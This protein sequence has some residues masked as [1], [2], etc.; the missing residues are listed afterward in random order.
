MSQPFFEIYTQNKITGGT[1][2]FWGLSRCFNDPGPYMFTVEWAETPTGEWQVVPTG[3][4][5]DTYWA[6]DPVQRLYAKEFELYYRIR[7]ETPNGQHTSFAQQAAGTWN[8]REWLIAR[9]ICRKEWLR[10]SKQVGVPCFLLKRK[11]AGPRCETCVDWDNNRD[12]AVSDCPDCYGTGITGGYWAPFDT[13]MDTST[14]PRNKEFAEN[15]GLKEDV[16]TEVR[17][18]GYPHVSTYDILVDKSSDRRWVVR[19][20]ENVAELRGQ[21]L[22]Y[23]AEIRL[24]PFTDPIYKIPMTPPEPPPYVQHEDEFE[25]PVVEPEEIPVAPYCPPVGPQPE[26][27][28][29]APEVQEEAPEEPETVEGVVDPQLG[30]NWAPN[31]DDLWIWYDNNTQTWAIGSMNPLLVRYSSQRDSD[32]LWPYLG[33]LDWF[34]NGTLDPGLAISYISQS[35]LFITGAVDPDV[36]GSYHTAG[37]YN[38]TYMFHRSTE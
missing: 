25:P 30:P 28:E 20:V 10:L 26:A 24:A 15:V 23:T 32:R 16:V 14:F 6:E 4:L 13:F 17:L 36:N 9:D 27:Q 2:I 35:N 29:E 19:K 1:V 8:K 11:I 12:S 34:Q 7:M 5:I 37:T 31:S 33:S 18:F 38:G 3:P 22:V 21:P